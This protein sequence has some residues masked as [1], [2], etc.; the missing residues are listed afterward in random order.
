MGASLDSVLSPLV[1][2]RY[3]L[4]VLVR[5]VLRSM[6]ENDGMSLGGGHPGEDSP[7][8]VNVE[9][10]VPSPL[11]VGLHFVEASSQNRSFIRDDVGGPTGVE[12]LSHVVLL[13]F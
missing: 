4:E 2:L 13:T 5:L 1:E 9:G 3:S 8:G 10:Q 12:K 11:G 6:E 7:V